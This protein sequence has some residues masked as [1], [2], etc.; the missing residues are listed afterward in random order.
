[1][2]NAAAGHPA[3]QGAGAARVKTQAPRSAG[4]LSARR[5]AGRRLGGPQWGF[6]CV[7]TCRLVCAALVLRLAAPR[8]LPGAPAATAASLAVPKTC[9]TWPAPSTR[10]C[11]HAN[12]RPALEVHLNSSVNAVNKRMHGRPSIP[13]GS[14]HFPNYLL[15]I[16]MGLQASR[17]IF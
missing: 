6:V 16:S 11:A 7:S 2:A 10:P 17:R 8:R 15:C 5:G 3:G 12:A 9:H 13:N 4:S 14:I 1:M